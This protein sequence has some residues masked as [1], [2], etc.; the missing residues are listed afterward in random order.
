MKDAFTCA[1]DSVAGSVS[2]LFILMIILL[3]G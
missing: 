3:I 2:V 1:T